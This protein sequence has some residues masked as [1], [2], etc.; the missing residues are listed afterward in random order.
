MRGTLTLSDYNSAHTSSFTIIPY[1]SCAVATF[2]YLG[3]LLPINY[4]RIIAFAPS[5]QRASLYGI[6]EFLPYSTTVKL[7]PLMILIKGSYL[8]LGA[9]LHRLVISRCKCVSIKPSTS[10]M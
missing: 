5:V 8:G 7:L 1:K 9:L 3:P 6:T 2:K 10:R 4:V